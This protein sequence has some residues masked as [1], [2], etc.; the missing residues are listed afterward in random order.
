M[1]LLPVSATYSVPPPA[2][3]ASAYGAEK[4]ASAPAPPAKPA[5][6][7]PGAPPPASTVTKPLASATA[8]TTLL[9]VSAT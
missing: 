8:R 7:A 4:R 2:A 1:A 3:S 6:R 5:V 9:P